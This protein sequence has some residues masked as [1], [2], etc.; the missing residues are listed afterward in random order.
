MIKNCSKCGVE[1]EGKYSYC[2]NCTRERNAAYYLSN[3]EREL[4]RSNEYQ[5]LN[6]KE[7][8]ERK[9]KKY[10]EIRKYSTEYQRRRRNFD[11][12]YKMIGNIRR[13][14]SEAFRYKNKRKKTMEMVGCSQEGLVRHLESMFQPGMSWE[15]YGKWH[16]DHIIPV[17][18][19]KDRE[20]LEKLCHYTNLQ[21]LWAVEN[22]RKSNKLA[23][24]NVN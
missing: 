23:I 6:S 24:L 5:R 14:T 13:N 9:S 4:K 15:N 16:I 18:L 2:S 12:I 1:K 19:A 8:K 7:I 20:H 3:R 22:L 10:S 21:P 17:S 11:P